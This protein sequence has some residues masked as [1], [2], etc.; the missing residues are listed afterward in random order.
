MAPNTTWTALR[1][2]LPE[3]PP[4]AATY[5]LA[6]TTCLLLAVPP[7]T[8]HG[9]GRLAGIVI[10]LDPGHN[11]RNATHPAQIGRQV[12][13]GRGGHKD[14][15][16]TGTATGSG[17]AEHAFNFD[18]ARR[19]AAILRA[20]GARVV[21]TR[22]D[23]SGVG[24]CVDSR[25]TSGNTVHANAVVSIHADGAPSSGRGFHIIETAHGR[26]TRA[27]AALAHALRAAIQRDTRT[28]PANY[29]GSGTGIVQR[30]D[31]AGLNFSTQPKVFVEFANMRNAADARLLTS[32][33]WRQSAAQALADGI[34]AFLHR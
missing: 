21:L 16:T 13:D 2:G 12:A 7:G 27:D 10:D 32:A 25:G 20:R 18:V 28:H 17:Y 34:Q 6:L 14:C 29:V 23:D 5:A 26:H 24:P 30:D 11:G 1:R 19:T 31:L 33:T 22:S 3:H 4:K 8:A 15:D 9:A